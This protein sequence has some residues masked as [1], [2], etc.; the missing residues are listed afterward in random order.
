MFQ[1]IEEPPYEEFSAPEPE[2][3]PQKRRKIVAQNT[4]A[5]N[6]QPPRRDHDDPMTSE[7]APSGND[8]RELNLASSE[9][10]TALARVALE[11][12]LDRRRQYKLSSEFRN[13]TNILGLKLFS[14]FSKGQNIC[15]SSYGM[16]FLAAVLDPASTNTE[17]ALK[18]VLKY[19]GLAYRTRTLLAES[20]VEV[21]S[22]LRR[23]VTGTDD[24]NV[25]TGVFLRDSGP[26]AAG[27]ASSKNVTRHVFTA[28][29]KITF[30]GSSQSA[31]CDV[32]FNT[33]RFA[34][35]WSCPF[36]KQ[37]TYTGTFLNNWTDKVPVQMM[38]KTAVLQ[39]ASLR[40]LG[41]DIVVL[42][43]DDGALS[44]VVFSQ[45]TASNPILLTPETLSILS[46]SLKDAL[47]T[48]H[49]PKFEL[50]SSLDLTTRMNKVFSQCDQTSRVEFTD[51]HQSASISV[52]EGEEPRV[53]VDHSSRHSDNSVT[54]VFD[55][56]FSV[57]VCERNS[58]LVL[59]LGKVAALDAA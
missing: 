18:E 41:T 15:L 10:T 6:K 33:A 7:K 40:D 19:G 38:R 42:P 32:L 13:I 2:C 30:E 53:S 29:F 24:V 51:V 45:R 56:P 57:M 27:R 59:Y 55:R 14:M 43:F 37:S 5:T 44:M 50:S 1:P 58:G 11:A 16:S 54:V 23:R 22:T 49:L 20:C 48:V 52:S 36:S 17:G 47:V 35:S 31:W 26:T 25:K 3:P 12:G 34:N 9:G 4:E 39:Y 21:V 28:E 46:R 8:T